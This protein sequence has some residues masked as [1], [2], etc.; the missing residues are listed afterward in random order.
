[1][2][3]SWLAPLVGEFFG[4]GDGVAM[5]FGG[6][7]G[8]AVVSAAVEDGD[9][10]AVAQEGAKQDFIAFL[11][12]FER[13]IH[14]SEAV[15][16]MVV[17]TCDPD[18]EI[19]G[20]NIER[21]REATEELFE[22]H[23]AFDVADGFDI[24]RALDFLGRVIFA[25]VDGVGED[26]WV[27]GEERSGAIALVGISIDDHDADTR[28]GGLEVA[29]GNGDVIE[30][31]V[32]LAMIG[33]GMM[34]AAG[35]ADGD[36]FGERGTAGLACGFDFGGAALVEFWGHGKAEAQSFFLIELTA[37]NFIEVGDGVNAS[38]DV[39]GGRLDLDDFF[40]AEDVTIEQHV[41]GDTEFFHG[42][43]VT[44]G[45]LEFEI[46]RVKTSHERR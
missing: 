2:K 7:F 43:G 21:T 41:F 31:T 30:D 6:E 24:H 4:G 23:A 19:G 38:E 28:S 1:M 44:M 3:K 10:N 39:G 36:A 8:L 25:D 9:G 34:G 14:L 46:L 11:Q 20:K 29:D 17:G 40:G 26:P 37:I 32:S 12:V 15:V 16:A 22:I 27:V 13:E 35:E 18:Y 5:D 33:K 45:K 42:K